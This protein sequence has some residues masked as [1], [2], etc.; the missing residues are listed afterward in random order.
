VVFQI[1]KIETCAR[2]TDASWKVWDSVFICCR[3]KS[4]SDHFK[5]DGWPTS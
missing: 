2:C 1:I 4:I 5:F 3:Q